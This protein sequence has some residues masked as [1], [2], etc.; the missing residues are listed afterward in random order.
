MTINTFYN[1]VYSK[2]YENNVL[3]SVVGG[4]PNT[5]FF[6]FLMAFEQHLEREEHRSSL[7][8]KWAQK[9]SWYSENLH[10]FFNTTRFSVENDGDVYD[11]LVLMSKLTNSSDSIKQL[12]E[13]FL[14]EA[15]S[16]VEV[17]FVS[18]GQGVWG[19]E[20]N[21]ITYDI[22]WS[23]SGATWGDTNTSLR[24]VFGVKI[25]FKYS[26]SD[27]DPLT[28]E[29]WSKSENYTMLEDLVRLFKP[30]G[31]NFE[32]ILLLEQPSGEITSVSMDAYIKGSATFSV[33][34][35]GYVQ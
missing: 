10:N 27:T 5:A 31:T 18:T 34:M 7:L 28:Y 19:D 6:Q 20:G 33:S 4:D 3:P 26:G 12:I 35:D 14:G 32:L 22:F 16:K 23:Q 13:L 8:R 17:V 1:R 29:F 25:T 30:P 11:R 24:A 21:A 15:A 2:Y 9:Y